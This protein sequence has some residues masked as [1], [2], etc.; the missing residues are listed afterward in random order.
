MKKILF[1][2]SLLIAA[3]TFAAPAHVNAAKFSSETG[4]G[5][6]IPAS[7]VP[8]AILSTFNSQYPTATNVRWELEREHG[9]TVYQA[10]FLLNGKR[11]K[12]QYAG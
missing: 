11:M 7:Q 4:K 12:V 3:S 2:A 1:A 8:A 10:Q 5:R 9:Q 6:H